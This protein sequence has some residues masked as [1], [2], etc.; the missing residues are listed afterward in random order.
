MH[1]KSEN[2]ASLCAHLAPCQVHSWQAE[3]CRPLRLACSCP[4][5]CKALS[6]LLHAGLSP[7]SGQLQ[8]GEMAGRVDTETVTPRAR[9]PHSLPPAAARGHQRPEGTAHIHHPLQ[10]LSPASSGCPVT[11]GCCFTRPT[12]MCPCQLLLV[13]RGERFHIPRGT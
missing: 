7:Q 2:G 8:Q 5:P 12:P 13:Q 11:C 10:N 9:P 1:R 3:P 4:A 6:H